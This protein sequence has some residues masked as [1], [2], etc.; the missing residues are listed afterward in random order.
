V[1][2]AASGG[3]AEA[4]VRRAIAQGQR[5]LT[6]DDDENSPLIELGAEPVGVQELVRGVKEILVGE[7]AARPSRTVAQSPSTVR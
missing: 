7:K 6:F 4:T 3:K 2:H 5:V 1:P